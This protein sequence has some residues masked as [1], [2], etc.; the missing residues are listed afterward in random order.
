MLTILARPTYPGYFL[1][2][3]FCLAMPILCFGQ[4]G[5]GIE[6]QRI[7]LEA[8]K[9]N[10]WVKA[11][12]GG[13]LA[14]QLTQEDLRIIESVPGRGESAQLDILGLADSAVYTR[15]GNTAGS[16]LPTVTF[17][18]D[19]SRQMDDSNLDMAREIIEE[20]IEECTAYTQTEFRIT[21]F[22]TRVELD[23]QKIDLQH[24]REI[25]DGI[26]LQ[27]DPPYFFRFVADELRN[28]AGSPGKHILVVLATGANNPRGPHFRKQLPYEGKDIK[29][30]VDNLPLSHHIYAIVFDPDHRNRAFNW[31]SRPGITDYFDRR[32][33]EGLPQQIESERTLTSNYLIVATP[34]DPLFRGEARRYTVQAGQNS[35]SKEFRLGSVSYPVDLQ[36]LPDFTE[37][38]FWFVMGLIIILAL[39]G[40]GSLWI[41][42]AREKKFIRKYV[43][44]YIPEGNR[45]RYDVLYNEPIQYG[46]L[47]VTKCRQ[48]TPFST[49]KENGWQCPNYPVCLDSNCGGEGAADANSFFNPAGIYLK[50]NWIWFGT[51]GG[52]IGWILTT[53]YR[54]SGLRFF[55]DLIAG[56]FGSHL[57]AQVSQGNPELITRTIMNNM[58]PGIFFAFGLI[59]M[60]SWVEE[61]RA[62]NRYSWIS[63]FGRISFRTVLGILFAGLVF[64]FG[65]YLQYVTGINPYLSG[66]ATWMIL[67]I[68]LG[69]IMSLR[70]SITA[71]KGIIAGMLAS[72]LSFHIYWALSELDIG[73]VQ[74]NLASM[75]IMGGVM[76]GV[77]VTVVSNLETYELEIISPPGFQRIIP[78]SKW[79]K[80]NVGVAIGKSPGSYIYVK[81]EDSKVEPD[82]A[83]LFTEAG[84]VFIR[85]LA[86][87]LVNNALIS[88]PVR[89]HDRDVIKLGRTGTTQFIFHEK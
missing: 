2:V 32:A 4:E 28:M 74:A 72:L 23:R 84:E 20:I 17:L 65:F 33:P 3:G 15:S 61:K 31:L 27:P 30:L 47:V 14:T 85:P 42:L 29:Q 78:I 13:R 41:P 21:T 77:M 39:L 80:S 19:I 75:L 18:L 49:W 5:I 60:L 52:F 69:L 48:V 34:A 6:L 40:V 45:V 22:H 66:L 43:K 12:R 63:S 16:S 62:S 35:S 36:R 9:L 55:D 8:D 64:Y 56:R 79:L 7:T 71:I 54:Q 25:L 38:F 86:E 51:L 50:L 11:T 24:A 58:L 53:L 57:P 81:W 10:F 70:S 26:S 82:H 68:A 44:P 67:G 88:K 89:L 87:V 59:L 73:F 83:E 1:L 46:E 76:G 37:W